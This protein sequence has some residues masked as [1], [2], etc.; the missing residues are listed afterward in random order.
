MNVERIVIEVLT[1]QLSMKPGDVTPDSTHEI[2]GMDS[3]D[4]VE[5]VMALEEEFGVIIHDE[6]AEKLR[7]VKQATAF[8]ETLIGA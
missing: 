3:L 6:D 7:T 4:D 2:L 5:V 8:I 1:E